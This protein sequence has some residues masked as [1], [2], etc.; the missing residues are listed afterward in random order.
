MAKRVLVTG[1]S[2]LFGRA[3]YKEFLSDNSWETLGLA[4]S[5]AKES[6]KKLD[7]TDENQVKEVI[8][9]FRPSVIIHS[10]AERKPD[11]VENDP[12]G[13][14]KLNLSATDYI[15][16]AAKSIGAWVLYISTDYVF[17]GKSPPYDEDAKPNPLNKYGQS[18]LEGEKITLEA[19]PENSV[20]R[21]PILYGDIEYIAE[22]AVTILFEKIVKGSELIAS[23]YEKRYP[24]HCDDIAYVIRQLADRRLQDPEKVHGVFHWSSNE[25]MT[26]Y[27]MSIAMASAFSLSTENIKADRT[28]SKG[29]P[30]P[31][32][33][34]LSCKKMEALVS[35]R[36][37][38]FSEGIKTV[39]QPY[40]NK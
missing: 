37:T 29:A 38:P 15:C 39:L 12:D 26:K 34:H 18:K 20:L 17:D 32:N 7:I 5:R 6:L 11:A 13:T 21:V 28:P 33:T 31:Y 8:N 16:Q 9:T 23:D 40:F 22:S 3:I 2:G 25:E 36:Q 27:D 10:A 30:R 4:F 19:S 24:T 35:G 14:K 1:A